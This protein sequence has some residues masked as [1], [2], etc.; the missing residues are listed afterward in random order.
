MFFYL[1]GFDCS[2]LCLAVQFLVERPLL[3]H[4]HQHRISDKLLSLCVCTITATAVWQRVS[5]SSS[6]LNSSQF[7]G[8]GREVHCSRVLSFT[9]AGG[10]PLWCSSKTC[11][12]G[13]GALARTATSALPSSKIAAWRAAHRDSNCSS[14]CRGLQ[15]TRLGTPFVV[16]I[17]VCGLPPL[18]QSCSSATIVVQS[19]TAAVQLGKACNEVS[20]R[21]VRRTQVPCSS[22]MVNR[23]RCSAADPLLKFRV[24][25][26]CFII[27]LL[28]TNNAVCLGRLCGAARGLVLVFFQV[29]KDICGSL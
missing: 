20:S 11:A 21:A 12:R 17:G 10:Y 14:V 9:G 22:W 16:Q 23:G 6:L 26:L 13:F 4:P 8:G 24:F 28:G 18:L 27:F 15:S 25:F 3:L 2:A 5:R 1:F 29:F 19:A 7:P